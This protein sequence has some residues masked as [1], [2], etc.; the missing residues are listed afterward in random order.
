MSLSGKVDNAQP[1]MRIIFSKLR[2][3]SFLISRICLMMVAA[4]WSQINQSVWDTSE[5]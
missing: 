5:D 4:S 3:M 1:Q 2:T